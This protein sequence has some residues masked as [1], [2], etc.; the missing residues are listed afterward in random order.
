MKA[1]HAMQQSYNAVDVVFQINKVIFQYGAVSVYCF[2]NSS[3]DI[4]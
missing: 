3:G 4:S 2:W 1:S